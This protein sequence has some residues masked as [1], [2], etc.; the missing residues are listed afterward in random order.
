MF[1]VD[2]FFSY[3]NLFVSQ[4]LNAFLSPSKD[5]RTHWGMVGAIRYIEYIEV[6]VYVKN[7]HAI[8]LAY[9][10]F[11]SNIKHQPEIPHDQ[12][13]GLTPMKN[14]PTHIIESYD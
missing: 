1:V 2:A 13:T 12:C 7:E 4:V 6:S 14:I 5:Y 8:V 9:R 10:I 11:K 3:L